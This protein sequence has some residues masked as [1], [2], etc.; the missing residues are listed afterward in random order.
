M[1]RSKRAAVAGLI[2]LLGSHAIALAQAPIPAGGAVAPTPA[3]DTAPSGASDGAAVR[4]PTK[5][6]V[7]K[8]LARN[9][10]A[11]NDSIDNL[12]A[13]PQT[14]AAFAVG[15]TGEAV[16]RPGTLRDATLQLATL[17]DANGDLKPGF[18]GEFAPF[19]VLFQ[20]QT[21]ADWQKNA[22]AANRLLDS[23]RLSL[24]TA[25]DSAA[26]GTEAPT[27]V[28]LGLRLSFL[29]DRDYR[30]NGAFIK[31]VKNALITCFPDQVTPSGGGIDEGPG[32]SQIDGSSAC[33]SAQTDRK[34]AREAEATLR[35][36]VEMA[37]RSKELQ[38]A[39]LTKAR[40]ALSVANVQ[41]ASEEVALRKFETLPADAAAG[42]A[43]KPVIARVRA[44]LVS[45]TQTA[46]LAATQLQQAE[47][48]AAASQ[49]ALEDQQKLHEQQL[50]KL[51]LATSEVRA[52]N[53]ASEFI[54]LQHDL[55]TKYLNQGHRLELA[56]ASVFTQTGGTNNATFRQSRGW[57]AYEYAFGKGAFG[58]A[59][60]LTFTS[61][62]DDRV[63][64]NADDTL[65]DGRLG[66]RFNFLAG[67]VDAALATGL[68]VLQNQGDALEYGGTIDLKFAALGGVRTGLFARSP[69]DGSPTSLMA[70]LAISGASGESLY[71]RTLTRCCLPR[72]STA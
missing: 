35:Q 57:L 54:S 64:A 53:D 45:A 26:T 32:Y 13:I 34:N 43:L 17:Y 10:E 55:E 47:L 69:F 44:D 21:L 39:A 1:S 31:A 5:S 12:L 68:A 18:N 23:V 6:E 46:D 19:R 63:V 61:N 52:M 16:A 66:V 58:A 7:E 24:A 22:N 36:A 9:L 72:Y 59:G 20:D 37:R 11:L 27:L 65:V 33:A 62:K 42:V 70:V 41:K 50:R 30:R 15:A 51:E 29:D 67:G 49:K 60:D 71:Q 28:S 4:E 8:D 48:A 40:I 14:P 25:R 3:A 2:A 56:T 38:D